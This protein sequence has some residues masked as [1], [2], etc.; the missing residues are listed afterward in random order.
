ML[1][2][3]RVALQVVLFFMLLSVAVALGDPTVGVAETV[4]AGLVGALLIWAAAPVRR[5]GRQRTAS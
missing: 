5:I 2:I 4:V 3:V 1:S